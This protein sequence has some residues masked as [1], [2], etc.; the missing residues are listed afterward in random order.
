MTTL[1]TF[2]AYDST[3]SDET[4]LEKFS[5]FLVAGSCCVAGAIWTLMYLFIFGLGLTTLL[6]F[7]FVII[8]GGSLIISHFTKK[9]RYAIYA[10]ILCI[11]YIT[12]FIQ[13]SIGGVLDSGFVM[14]WALIGPITALMFFRFRRSIPWFVLYLINVMI[15][16]IFDDF[17]SINGQ[18]VAETTKTLFFMMNVSISSLVVFIFAGYYVTT[19]IESKKREKALKEEL[20]ALTV[21]I[22]QKKQDEDV[23][24]IVNSEFFKTLKKEQTKRKKR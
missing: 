1:K 11:I 2:F 10:E 19:A 4:R 7:L 20:Q 9:H 23:D 13:W 18:E 12:S 24:Q 22:D 16:I 14:A 15:T 8:V 21:M 3:D 17:F 5:I 6:P